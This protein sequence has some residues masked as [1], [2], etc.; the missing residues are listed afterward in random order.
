MRKL[1]EAHTR[2]ALAR[3]GSGTFRGFDEFRKQGCVATKTK[4]GQGGNGQYDC[5]YAAT[6][7][8]QPGQPPL[9]VNGKGR[10]R[11]TDTGLAFE[12]LGAQPR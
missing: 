10:F 4:D 2:R 6:F 7:A 12:D 9:T 1:V 3:Q 5:Y 11:P 8:P